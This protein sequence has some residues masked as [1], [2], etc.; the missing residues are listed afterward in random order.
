MPRIMSLYWDETNGVCAKH[1]IPE[2]PCLVCAAKQDP[3]VQV[4]FE[5][6]DLD[7]AHAENIPLTDLVPQD[8][9]FAVRQ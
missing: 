4:R 3:D 5:E 6:I 9:L 7:V 1:F 8:F 2:L